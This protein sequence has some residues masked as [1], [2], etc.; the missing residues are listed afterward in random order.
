MPSSGLFNLT[1]SSE[2]V[3][4]SP[5]T[6]EVGETWGITNASETSDDNGRKVDFL[7]FMLYRSFSL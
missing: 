3:F 4:A 7:G 2:S 1:T 5:K 6:G